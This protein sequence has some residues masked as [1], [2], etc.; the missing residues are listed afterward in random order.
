MIEKLKYLQKNK[1]CDKINAGY[2]DDKDY[3]DIKLSH[4]QNDRI[5]PNEKRLKYFQNCHDANR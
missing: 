5:D 1:S 3:G 2:D 4:E